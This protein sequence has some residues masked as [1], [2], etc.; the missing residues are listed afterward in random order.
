VIRLARQIQALPLLLVYVASDR[1]LVRADAGR[2]AAIQRGVR[3][4]FDSPDAPVGDILYLLGK[5]P[6]YR[7][8]FYFRATRYSIIGK[9]IAT[10]AG[11]IWRGAPGLLIGGGTIGPGLYIEHGYGTILAAE[12]IGRDCWINQDVTLSSN[13]VKGAT[14]LGDRVYVHMG[15]KVLGGTV[16]GDD[17]EIGANA[18]V[19]R[20]VP[21]RTIAVGVPAITHR[22]N[23]RIYEPSA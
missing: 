18:V 6:E 13:R 9:L 11:T 5:L 3:D 12:K 15:A 22:P 10:L 21:A 7:S 20:D 1:S 17:S 2:W 8:L 4:A 14:S 19:T 16:L 23:P